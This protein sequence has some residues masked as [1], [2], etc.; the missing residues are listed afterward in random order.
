MI[1]WLLFLFL[2]GCLPCS[3]TAQD[4]CLSVGE[5]ETAQRPGFTFRSALSAPDNFLSKNPDNPVSNLPFLN[6]RLPGPAQPGSAS[7]G[8]LLPKWN[9]ASLPFFCRVEH[10]WGKK[11]PFAFKFRLGSV[12][13]VNWLEGKTSW[14]NQ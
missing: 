2:T 8:N 1:R 12:E 9:P 13:Y 5:H 11:L 10:D 14:I 6:Q 7:Q 3:L 4:A